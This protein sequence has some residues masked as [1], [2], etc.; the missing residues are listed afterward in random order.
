M[1]SRWDKFLFIC[2]VLSLTVGCDQTTKRVA[3]RTLKGSPVRSMLKD[4]FRLQF[5]KNTGGFLGFG[6]KFPSRLKFWGFTIFPIVALLGMFLFGL[7]SREMGFWH[8]LMLMLI[9][10]GGAG[11]LL[12]RLLLSGEVTDF[13]NM[14]IGSLRTGI[15]NVAD[16]AIMVGM[17]GLI[18]LNFQRPRPKFPEHLWNQEERDY[19]YGKK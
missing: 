1:K 15:F 7:F 16:V 19:V 10:G 11:N 8:L 4:T 5:V 2:L 3:E 12:D 6:A 14:G 17:F 18:G 9:V 13:M